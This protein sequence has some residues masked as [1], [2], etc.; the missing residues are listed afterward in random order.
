M[1]ELGFGPRRCKLGVLVKI[2]KL[3]YDHSD[4][5][6][7][8]SQYTSK[9]NHLTSSLTETYVWAHYQLLKFSYDCSQ[10]F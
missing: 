3:L 4:S 6:D 7:Q 1:K 8:Y 5:S 2:S 10:F 9:A